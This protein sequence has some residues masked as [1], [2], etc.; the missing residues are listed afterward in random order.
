MKLQKIKIAFIFLV[1]LLF[2]SCSSSRSFLEVKKITEYPQTEFLATLENS[3]SKDKNAVYCVTLLYA[4]EE[5]RNTLQTTLE[6]P[7]ELQ[8]TQKDLVLLNN[9]TSFKDVLEEGE[10]KVKGLIEGNSVKTEA[11]FNKSLPFEFK[12]SSFDNEL[13][14]DGKKVSSF[15]VMGEDKEAEKVIDILYYKSDDEFILKLNTKDRLHEI[16]LFKTQEN[17]ETLAQ[18]NAKIQEKIDTASDEK[19]EEENKYF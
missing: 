19:Y 10:Y 11:E 5:V 14:F 1:V 9:S 3:I 2:G 13:I 18:M 16:I 8:D 7:T 17:F 6:V 4:W 12:L 15:G